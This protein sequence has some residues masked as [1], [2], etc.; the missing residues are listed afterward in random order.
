MPVVIPCRAST[1]IV[2]AVRMRSRL[3]G[4]ISGT[5]S[6]SSAA[7]SMGTQITPLV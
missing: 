4:V 7:P 2:Y 1:E 6:R 3:C 5:A